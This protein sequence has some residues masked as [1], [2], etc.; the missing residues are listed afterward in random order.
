MADKLTTPGEDSAEK[1]K[2][3]LRRRRDLNAGAVKVT[4]TTAFAQKDWETLFVTGFF[5]VCLLATFWMCF[6]YITDSTDPNRDRFQILPAA[7]V[8]VMVE[9]WL[10]WGL[11][12][13]DKLV[14]WGAF[15]GLGTY[16]FFAVPF[17]FLGLLPTTWSVV[18]IVL[19]LLSLVSGFFLFRQR[20][21]F[22]PPAPPRRP[23]NPKKPN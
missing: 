6:V 5:V 20:T 7:I 13:Y 12:I 2:A 10:I 19:S 16:L 21:R 4:K 1:I 17:I 18:G 11:P 3:E 14:F 22:L 15:I 23:A 9:V 8:M